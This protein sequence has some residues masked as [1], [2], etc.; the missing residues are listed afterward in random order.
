MSDTTSTSPNG[1]ATD[2]PSTHQTTH[3]NVSLR[4]RWSR[5]G[6]AVVI[7][8]AIIGASL[9]LGHRNGWDQIG[10][11]GKNAQLLPKVGEPAPELFTISNSGQPVLLSQLHG[12][13]VWINFWGSWCYPCRSEMPEF[14]KA[15]DRLTPE[16]VVILPIAIGE[17]VETALNYRASVGGDF[18]VYWDPSQVANAIGAGGT[19]EAAAMMRKMQQNWQVANFPTHVFIDANG[20]VQAIALKEL[21]L[22]QALD[23]GNLILNPP[24]TPAKE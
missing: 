16:G 21:D 20:I 19:P 2:T 17:P 5:I 6:L 24:A 3:A 10:T 8:L 11:G 23:Y 14:I 4:E 9:F 13:P 22:D 7:A 1:V 18:P 12:H 15:Y